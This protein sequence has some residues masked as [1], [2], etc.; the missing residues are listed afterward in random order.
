MDSAIADIWAKSPVR[1]GDAG[2]SLVAHT[3][4]V[5]EGLVALRARQPRLAEICGEPRLWHRAALACA[6]HD[7]G[8]C[9]PGFQRML[10]GGARFE[11][12][13]EVISLALLPWLIGD[14]EQGDLSWIAAGIVTHHRNLREIRRLYPLP[15]PSM[16]LADGCDTLRGVLDRATIGMMWRVATEHLVPTARDLGLIEGA[17]PRQSSD[18]PGFGAWETWLP[19]AVRRG[20]RAV[21]TIAREAVGLGPRA[22]ACRFVRGL[23]LLCDH[24]GSAGERFMDVKPLAS[25]TSMAGVLLRSPGQ[26]LY[27]HQ[28]AAIRAG[29]RT[30]LI[31]P[32]GTGKTE[33]AL[34][35][36][37]A[38]RERQGATPPVF[39]VLPYQAS[40]NAMRSRLAALFGEDAV[41]L[42]HSRAVQALYRQLLERGYSP[43][44]AERLAARGRSL[45]RLHV[46]SVRVL[47]PYQLLRG[48]YQL[49]GHPAL[50]TDAAGGTFIID[51]I[52]AYEATRL[53]MIV[54][55]LGHLVRELGASILVMSATLPGVLRD[56]L[57][58]A[59][60]PLHEVT[61][62]AETMAQ[63][64]RHR[65]RLQAEDLTSEEALNAIT[66]VARKGLAVLV[67]A[68]TVGRAQ[69]IWKGLRAPS[70]LGVEHVRLL[71]GRFCGRDRF[72]KEEALRRAVA[73]DLDPSQR[74][75]VVLVATQV[76]EVSL[77][78]DFDV[79]FS[80]PAPLEAL[81]QRF[82][83]VN[84]RRRRER[85]DVVVMTRVPDGDPVYP[86]WLVARTLNLLSANDGSNVDE[87]TVQTWLD[88]VYAGV[89]GERWKGEVGRAR[90]EFRKNVLDALGVFE[91]STELTEKFDEMFD[92]AEVLPAALA[93]EFDALSEQRPLLAPSLLVPVTSGQFMWLKRQHRLQERDRGVAVADVPYD[94]ETGLDLSTARYD[95]P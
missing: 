35:W 48:A 18:L 71:H 44:G 77:D 91:S 11:P 10:R 52:H 62:S 93:E 80:D 81:V 79:L 90:F 16:E 8:K 47:S 64:S 29:G 94:A 54:E 70:R 38:Q 78:V 95:A 89:V 46:A 82:G 53:G 20:L 59:I 32:T 88:D 2:E 55:A 34:L 15:D 28:R 61:A 14:D 69:Q 24:A 19:A 7:L 3:R 67:V 58:E 74:R 25:A 72:E 9:A 76:V 73:T 33:A 5:L 31:A 63:F 12:R 56:I 92:G 86:G 68:T 40:L 45:A 43:S 21:E 39:Y 65:L 22:V 51:E 75:P 87:T 30:I 50:W 27:E 83:R 84:R 4:A 57:E 26:G 41:A 17:G 13:H 6:L 85:S 23:V 60:G 66:E 36:A 49:P 37:A 42:Q 1:G